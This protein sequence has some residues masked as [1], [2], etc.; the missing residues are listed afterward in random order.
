[1]N[2]FIFWLAIG[3]SYARKLSLR[4]SSYRRRL[5]VVAF[6]PVRPPRSRRRI[7]LA[8]DYKGRGGPTEPFSRQISACR[9]SKKRI[10]SYSPSRSA[11]TFTGAIPSASGI[12]P[13]RFSLGKRHQMV[14]VSGR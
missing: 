2:E 12:W 6:K 9:I 4:H 11:S 7:L 1:M 8:R 13:G 3:F 10:L 5:F 14:G